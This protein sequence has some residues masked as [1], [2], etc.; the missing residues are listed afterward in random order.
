MRVLVLLSAM[1]CAA[2]TGD[3]R[4]PSLNDPPV[5]V[6]CR[7]AVTRVP[8]HVLV[9]VVVVLG[10]GGGIYY[11]GDHFDPSRLLTVVLR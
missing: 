1:T 7:E 8:A 9:R 11:N 3:W 2:P 6:S 4:S 10:P 5:D